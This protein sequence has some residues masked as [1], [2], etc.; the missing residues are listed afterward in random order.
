MIHSLELHLGVLEEVKK[1]EV[2]AMHTSDWN[3]HCN[4]LKDCLESLRMHF[5][6]MR[7]HSLRERFLLASTPIRKLGQDANCQNFKLLSICVHSLSENAI[8]DCIQEPFRNIFSRYW[9]ISD[10]PSPTV[11]RKKNN[12]GGSLNKNGGSVSNHLTPPT[13]MEEVRPRRECGHETLPLRRTGPQ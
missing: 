6:R 3:A 13:T 7:S 1:A 12:S 5:L 9:T 10:I 2:T 4:F 8:A 11:I